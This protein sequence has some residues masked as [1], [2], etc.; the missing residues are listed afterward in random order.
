MGLIKA[1]MGALGGTLADQWKEFFYC[2]AMDKEVM[3][4]KGQKRV[5]G[6]SS[7]TVTPRTTAWCG[8]RWRPQAA[9]TS[10]ATERN[11]SSG[12]P[13][14]VR[15]RRANPAAGPVR[16]AAPAAP[17]AQRPGDPSR[18]KRAVPAPP[19]GPSPLRKNTSPPARAGPEGI[20][21]SACRGGG[22]FHFSSYPRA[23]IR[24]QQIPPYIRIPQ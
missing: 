8:R 11:A 24:H 3:V 10:S 12:P 7:N 18:G 15:L 17:K 9:R 1:G 21:A 4:T 20:P 19:A 13:L 14:S 22:N 23:E 6:R 2:E 5:S 16:T